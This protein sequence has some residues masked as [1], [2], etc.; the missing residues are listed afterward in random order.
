MVF[1]RYISGLR[2][3]INQNISEDEAIDMLSQHFITKPIFDAI[4]KDFS[5]KNPVSIIIEAALEYLGANKLN[6]TNEN[7]EKFY[8]EQKER[9]I[10]LKTDEGKQ[11]R[12]KD[13]YENFFRI[14]L[15][16]TAQKLGIVYTPNEVVDFIVRSTDWALKNELGIPEGFSAENVDILDLFTGTGTFIVRLIQPGL[17]SPNKI[18]YKL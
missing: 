11:K 13:L 8:E 1:E 12:I 3:S 2:D 16:K 6:E 4:F 9:F 15:P 17:I 18:E 5:K 7:L 10:N 14:A